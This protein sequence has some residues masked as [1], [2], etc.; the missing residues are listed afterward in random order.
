[1]ENPEQETPETVGK[2]QFANEVTFDGGVVE[3]GDKDGEVNGN[4]Y[5]GSV[6]RGKHDIVIRGAV[7]GSP[8][9]QCV[10]EGGGDVVLQGSASFAKIRGH[11]IV[12]QGDVG[13]SKIF[14]DSDVEVGGNLSNTDVY[15]GS[16]SREIGLLGKVREEVRRIQ[17]QIDESKVR[18]RSK[19]RSF[20]RDYQQLDLRLGDILVQTKQGL[21]IDLNPFYRTL[22]AREESEVDLVLEEFFLK[23]VVSQL[24]RS[25]KDYISR[26]PGRR[27]IFFKLISDLRECLLMTRQEDKLC[28]ANKEVS[29]RRKG[30]LKELKE[31]TSNKLT[32]GAQ[33]MEKV[34]VQILKI[35]GF[36]ETSQGTIEI[37]KQ[38]A[39]ARTEA[40]NGSFILKTVDFKGRKKELPLRPQALTNGEF[41][42]L[43]EG[44]VWRRKMGQRDRT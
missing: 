2:V 4:V 13:D 43:E 41:K 44:I 14:S 36:E 25:N 29:E 5:A 11:N 15:V 23:I 9:G 26:N 30:I 34:F 21:S 7:A 39:E 22:S 10:V 37:E 18:S 28:E 27:K 3:F 1:M 8:R 38:V 17:S 40:D 32:V 24:T 12:A 20:V 35:H 42:I 19:A 6:I 31:G 16:R 33:V